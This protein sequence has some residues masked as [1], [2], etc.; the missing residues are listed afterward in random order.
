[1]RPVLITSIAEVATTQLRERTIAVATLLGFTTSLLI[2]YIN[3]FVQNEP[4]KLGAKVGMIYGS[5]SLI[6]LAFV[7]FVVPEMKG[8]SLEEIDELFHANIP[9]WKTKDYVCTGLGT[10]ITS[11]QNIEGSRPS[12]DGKIVGVDGG[13]DAGKRKLDAD[14]EGA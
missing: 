6:A 1:M 2:T 3:P 4:G 11:I 8:R 7:F 10:Q 12:L 5:I 13:E 9:A 14:R